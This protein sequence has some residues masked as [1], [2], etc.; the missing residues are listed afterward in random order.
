M[1]SV[2]VVLVMYGTILVC[3]NLFWGVI[4]NI[5]FFGLLFLSMFIT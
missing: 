2:S 1:G 4:T 5:A 3:L